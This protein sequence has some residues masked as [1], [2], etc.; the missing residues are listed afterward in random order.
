MNDNNI[1][2]SICCITFNQKDFIA[3]A[4]D[5]FLMQKTTFP[6]EILI[7]DDASTDGTQDILKKYEMEYD[8]IHVVYEL[9][10]QY[11]KGVSITSTFLLPIA[12]GKYIAFCE[13]DDYWTSPNKLQKQ[14][15]YMEKNPDCTLCFHNAI[16]V[17]VNEKMV[18]NS[19]L[20]KNRFYEKYFKR[21]NCVYTPD[22]MIKLDFAPTN[23]LL[24]RR[25]D[26]EKLREYRMNKHYVCGDLLSRIFYT[27]LGYAFFIDET[28]SAY[29][30]GVPNSASQSANVNYETKIKT[31][32]GHIQ[33]LNEFDA[34]TNKKYHQSIQEAKE[35]KLFS[36]YYGAGAAFVCFDKKFKHFFKRAS[37]KGRISFWLRSLFP[38]IYKLL[39]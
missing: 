2:V 28:L 25:S 7:H 35:L 17:D 5:S 21:N 10:N 6:Y 27:S 32:C 9:E 15:D 26:A 18:K 39:K 30:Q 31:L 11:S 29:R 14:V 19:F 24:Y 3:K 33:I 16:I 38:Y 23:S 36:H 22:D 8:N 1:M 37:L 34:F 4:L 20:P 12:K 13:G